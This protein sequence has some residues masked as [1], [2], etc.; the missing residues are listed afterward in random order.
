MPRQGPLT[1]AAQF[2]EAVF[3]SR[4]VVAIQ[5]PHARA[6]QGLAHTTP[7]GTDDGDQFVGDMMDQRRTDTCFHVLQLVV[8]GPDGD[9]DL[10]RVGLIGGMHGRADATDDQAHEIDDRGEQQFTSVLLFGGAVEQVVEFFGSE[11]VIQGAAQHHGEGTVLHKAV[12]D[13][14]EDHGSTSALEKAV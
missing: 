7:Q 3:R 10:V 1:Q 13:L 2:L 9:A 4:E 11:G 8:Q 12:E 14:T 6:R 5:D